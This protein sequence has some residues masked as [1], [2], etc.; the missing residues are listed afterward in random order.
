MCRE[1]K[2]NRSTSDRALSQGCFTCCQYLPENN[3]K[4]VENKNET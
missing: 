4:K 3:R 1:I 2:S